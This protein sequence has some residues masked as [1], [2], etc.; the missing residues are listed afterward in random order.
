MIVNRQILELMGVCGESLEHFTNVVGRGDANFQMS[1][2][3]AVR[4]LRTLEASD[5][6]T[7]RGWADLVDSYA[8]DHRYI[9]AAAQYAYGDYVLIG[10]AGQTYQTIEAAQSARKAAVESKYEQAL[11]DFAGHLYIAAVQPSNGGEIT[12]PTVAAVDGCSY[13]V[14]SA[15]SGE[16]ERFND[17]ASARARLTEIEQLF[18]APRCVV[19]IGRQIM[20][21]GA[22]VAI[23]ILEDE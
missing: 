5:P 11:R 18:L 3:D 14:F 1:L 20:V 12:V 23:D 8:T 22:V 6:E 13:M 9:K 7:Y 21:D 2:D 16:H 10:H 15:M 4:Y 19:L 17:F